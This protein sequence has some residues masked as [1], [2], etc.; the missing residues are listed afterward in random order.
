MQKWLPILIFLL[1]SAWCKYFLEIYEI[2]ANWRSILS[3][4]HE[5]GAGLGVEELFEIDVFGGTHGGLGDGG[6]D[7]PYQILD[8]ADTLTTGGEDLSIW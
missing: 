1:F 3:Q 7:E 5:R 2:L 4:Y 8:N 6:E